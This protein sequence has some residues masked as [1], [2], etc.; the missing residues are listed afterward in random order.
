MDFVQNLYQS[1]FG[2][3]LNRLNFERVQL[4]S[5]FRY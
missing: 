1:K 4:C 3:V 5:L 2:L